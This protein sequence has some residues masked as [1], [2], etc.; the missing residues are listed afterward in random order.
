MSEL[1]LVEMTRKRV[2]N[3]LLKTLTDACAYCEGRGYV[4]SV[5]TVGYEV[6][7]EVLRVGRGVRTDS[8]GIHVSAQVADFLF[9]EG[10][11]LLEEAERALGKHTVTLPIAAY[12][13][14][15]YDVIGV[16]TGLGPERQLRVL[17]DVGEA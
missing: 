10:R 14:E 12:H 2:S 13:V 15:D 16:D 7:R 8:L 9:G 17:P 11:S 4:K 1:G 5:A 6:L 3:S